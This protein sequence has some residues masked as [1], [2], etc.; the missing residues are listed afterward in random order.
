MCFDN[1]LPTEMDADVA[2]VLVD[3]TAIQ[4]RVAELGRQ[5][6]E[7]Y[8]GKPLML[9]GILRGACV[10]LSDLIR[11]I[12]IPIQVDFMAISSYVGTSTSGE[13][14]ILKDLDQPVEG[15][16]VLIVEDIADTGLTL[17]YISRI[18]AERR[19]LSVRTCVLLDKPYRRQVPVD[20]GYCGF[21]IPDKFV[22]GY[23][24]DFNQGYRNLRYVGVLR[25]ELYSKK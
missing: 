22:V 8:R 14:K 16:H 4:R 25:S 6:S 2:E 11:Y 13:V 7:D 20:I 15:F 12:T 5:I 24:I 3:Q 21:E 23:G 10:F 18:I 17:S 19:P 9:V 1:D